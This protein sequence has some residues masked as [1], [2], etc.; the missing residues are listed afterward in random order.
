MQR[1]SNIG[2]LLRCFAVLLCALMSLAT[3]GGP[4]AAEPA[5]GLKGRLIV[6]YQGW[7]GC[8]GDYAGNNQWQHWFFKN[9]P[10]ANHLSVDLLPSLRQLRQEDLC[11]TDLRRRD[12]SPIRL[13]SAQNERVV[14][15]HF[16]WM[17]EHGIDGAA[18]QR[19]VGPLANPQMKQR[20]DHVI[21]NVRAGAEASGR[22]FFIAYDVSGANPQ[23]VVS[24]IRNDWQHLIK[25]LKLTASSSYLHERGK[26]VLELW[27]FGFK[28]RPGLPDQVAAL[29]RDLK[30]GRLGL[31]AATLI[32]GV[33][34]N[35]RTL[36][37]DSQTDP[38]WAQIYRN[39]DVISPWSVGRFGDDAGA[40]TFIRVHVLPDLTETKR[41]GI[42][43][44][45]VIF[46][47]FSWFNLQSGRGFK[48]RA[49][50]N[51]I[52]RRCGNF[53]WHQVFDLLDAGV[54]MLYAAMFD[55]VDEGTAMFPT[56]TREDKLPNGGHMVFLNQDGCFLP[57]DWYLRVTG[58]AAKFLR[59]REI[60]PKRL[61]AVLNP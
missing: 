13:Y 58:Q 32:G 23:T 20:G 30:D 7:F 50:L 55:E 3:Q 10:D 35:W 29:I 25:D 33:P 28:D 51:Q 8:P 2:V 48:E 59:N 52:P 27:G 46:P 43:Y 44:M 1:Y 60:P 6:G 17:A 54:E 14:A 47:G 38:R 11:D 12:G 49:I 26:P 19:F 53:L 22:V 37:G 36:E 39:Y 4:E 31:P 45:P 61:D 40:D 41:L 56:E 9:T 18:A 16:Q 57:D 15:T 21:M 42:D 24:D 34:T 5:N